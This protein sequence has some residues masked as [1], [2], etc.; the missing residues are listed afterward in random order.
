MTRE[1]DAVAD[2]DVLGHFLALL[3]LARGLLLLG[4][5]RRSRADLHTQAHTST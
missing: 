3:A 2:N 1:V 5:R 4:A